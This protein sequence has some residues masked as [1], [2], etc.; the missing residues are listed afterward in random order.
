MYRHVLD[1]LTPIL[2]ELAPGVGVEWLQSGS[3]K[4]AT[5]LDAELAAGATK[6]DLVLTSDP[7]WYERLARAGHLLPYASLRSLSIPR[8][9]LDPEGR[10]VTSR[11]STMVIAYDERRVP[12]GEAPRSFEALFSER[13]KGKV[14]IPDPLGSGTSF[15]TVAFLTDLHGP[16]FLAR[17]R[18]AGT[19]AAGG[20]SAA[21]ARLE[22]GEHQVAFVLLENVL[23]ARRN[24][25]PIGFVLPEE[26]PVLIPG[27]IAILAR[28]KRPERAKRIYDALLSERAQRIIVDGDL[29]SPFEP[30][31]PPAGAPP[32]AE[33][34]RGRFTWSRAFLE[35]SLTRTDDLRRALSTTLGG[36]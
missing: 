25:S 24:G 9:L 8:E 11:L 22:S 19:V 10:Y 18:D 35:R 17:M 15:T 28:S 30:L 2:Q 26:G 13:W 32:L 23:Q 21:I 29:H 33:L 4:L 16:A 27:P 20:N 36:H 5:R 3:E 6:A 7:L 14:T 12:A 34:T 31:P 1:R